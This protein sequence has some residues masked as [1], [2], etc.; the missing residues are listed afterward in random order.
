MVLWILWIVYFEMVFVLIEKDRVEV[1]G[2]VGS[3]VEFVV[4]LVEFVS[5]EGLF[6]LWLF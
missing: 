1:E 4:F 5:G 3:V 6:V 2:V